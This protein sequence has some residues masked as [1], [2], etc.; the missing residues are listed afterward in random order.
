MKILHLHFETLKLLVFLTI[1]ALPSL[2]PAL[3]VTVTMAMPAST[4][5]SYFYQFVVDEN[6]FTQV[7]VDYSSSVSGYSWVFVPNFSSWNWEVSSGVLLHTNI[8]ETARVTDA[9]YYFYRA[10]NFSFEPRGSFNMR[11]QFN[12][13]TGALIIEPQGIFFSPQIGFKD[14]SNAG[15]EVFLPEGYEIVSG[16]A[17]ALGSSSYP[18]DS[19]PSRNHARF[20]LRENLI[21]LQIEFLTKLTTP[22]VITLNQGNFNFNAVKRYESYAWDILGLFDQVYGNLVSLFNVTLENVDAQFYIPDF[23]Y[24][25]SEGGYVPFTRGE[26]GAIHINVAL[27]RYIKGFLEVVSLHELVHHFLWKTGISPDDLLWFHEGMAQYISV[28]S[29][30]RW[31]PDGYEGALYEKDRLEENAVQINKSTGGNFNFLLQWKP[32]NDPPNMD[33]YYAAAY[34]V[35]SRLA[36][37]YGG[38]EYYTR[39]FEL[40][41]ERGVSDNDLLAYY[42]SL[43]ADASVVQTLQGWGFN[44]AN[45][46]TLTEEVRGAIDKLNPMFQPYKSIAEYLYQQALIKLE[47]EDGKGA[48]Q[49]LRAA[50]FLAN[51]APLLTLLSMVAII[52]AVIYLS[53]KESLKLHKSIS[54]E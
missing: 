38:L 48:S 54:T 40:I 24:F 41:K 46:H 12:M 16:H 13:S 28:E 33:S 19:I 4:S 47:E 6:G 18:P 8:V 31:Y 27:T 5:S 11:I 10:F 2:S 22:E 1:L 39:F 49:F 44:V 20:N 3:T 21:R 34:Y 15:A 9:D 23:N 29:I 50:L 45:L 53:K 42:L 14:G 25:L 30:M 35:T 7:T 51:S 17:L 37:N 36:E 26:I 32:G 43:A 52:I